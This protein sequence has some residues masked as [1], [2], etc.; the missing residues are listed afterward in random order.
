VYFLRLTG[1]NNSVQ[2]RKITL[3]RRGYR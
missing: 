3:F 2:T 1:P